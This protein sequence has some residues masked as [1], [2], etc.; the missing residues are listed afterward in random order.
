MH[1]FGSLESLVASIA[2]ARQRSSR[3]V[4]SSF[5]SL[6]ALYGSLVVIS[7]GMRRVF[8]TTTL[9]VTYRRTRDEIRRCVTLGLF[10]SSVHI[11]LQL[12]QMVEAGR[13]SVTPRARQTPSFSR[14]GALGPLGVRRPA[15][16]RALRRPFSPALSL[17]ASPPLFPLLALFFAFSLPPLLLFSSFALPFASPLTFSAC[18]SLQQASSGRSSLASVGAAVASL[19]GSCA[20]M[21]APCSF[22]PSQFVAGVGCVACLPRS[23]SLPRFSVRAC[24]FARGRGN[25]PASVSASLQ[26]LRDD[27][28]ACCGRRFT[29]LPRRALPLA[30]CPPLP[31]SVP[32]SSRSLSRPVSSSSTGRRLLPPLRGL[33]SLFVCAFFFRLRLVY[34]PDVSASSRS[35]L[36]R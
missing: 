19:S 11:C 33:S 16:I 4:S 5:S 3:R 21:S 36:L 9:H 10:S 12:R 27:Q 28:L 26:S 23:V 34:A 14:A 13:R 7:F 15:S 31:F 30:R 32:P 25:H 17:A 18:A 6:V 1:T 2:A 29:A 35:E 8:P 22:R 20:Q 24:F